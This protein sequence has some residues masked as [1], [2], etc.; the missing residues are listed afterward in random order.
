[1]SNFCAPTR[2]SRQPRRPC[3]FAGW[4]SSGAPPVDC[5]GGLPGKCELW[6]TPTCPDGAV[7]V[8][9]HGGLGQPGP[10]PSFRDG[11]LQGFAGTVVRGP[12]WNTSGSKAN[13]LRYS[14]LKLEEATHV[15]AD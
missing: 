4:R 15:P 6:Q 12:F 8:E 2:N 10:P 13:E 11:A 9:G 7:R 1:M 5:L 3:D 14:G